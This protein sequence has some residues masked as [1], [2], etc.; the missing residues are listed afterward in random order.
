MFIY[1]K[2][3]KKVLILYFICQPNMKKFIFI[4]IFIIASTILSAQN[5]DSQD[6]IIPSY[7]VPNTD[8]SFIPPKYF[9]VLPQANTLLHPT[10]S[11]TIQVNEI[12]GSPYPML[13]KNITKEYI[14]KQG[15]KFISKKDTLTDDGK[16]ATYFLVSFKTQAQDT[17]HTVIEYERF[18]FFTGTYNK[19]IW[20]NANYPVI[21]RDVL[22]K[23]LL[24][25]LL[26]VKF[27]D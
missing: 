26:T 17:L 23:V 22:A 15:V 24:K 6:T 27:K 7:K 1:K 20:I 18:M 4:I 16:K 9:M 19:T 12:N 11:S 5:T 10:S 14:E 25:S 21:A 2:N 13:V 8:V 3:I